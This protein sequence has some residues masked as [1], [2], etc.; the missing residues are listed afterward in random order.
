MAAVAAL[1]LSACG[2][3]TSSESS[4]D[5]TVATVQNDKPALQPIVD[6]FE[7]AHPGVKVT[8]TSADTSPYQ[9]TLQTQLVANNGPDVFYTYP[10]S[11]NPAA[12]GLLAKA[13]YLKDLSSESFVSQIPSGIQDLTKYQG[14]TYVR[15]MTVG[16]I[17]M[18]FNMDALKSAGL[19]VPDTWTGVLQLCASAKA[20]GKTAFALGGGTMS[21]VQFIDYALI[22]SLVYAKDPSFNQEMSS[23]SATFAG[24]AGWQQAMNMNVDMVKAGCF[25][26][27]P[28]G[29]QYPDAAK[30]V[31]SGQAFGIVQTQGAIAQLRVDSPSGNFELH[32]FP[33][34]DNPSDTYLASSIG[35]EY[36]INAHAKNPTLAQQFLDFLS[37]DAE[38]DA[39]ATAANSVP[40]I[41]N[42]QSAIPASIASIGEYQKENKT[43]PYPDPYWPNAQVQQAHLTGMQELLSGQGSV[44]DALK[45]M[46]SAYKG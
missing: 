36:A 15:P 25:E 11:G 23:G 19:T 1:S 30:L 33:A 16:G 17:G 5:L 28:L 29:V 21:N 44:A 32:P 34:G 4:Q 27:D 38:E 31:A 37:S 3:S 46:D 14:K 22:P 13:G 6:A 41:Q 24:S 12:E 7:K 8:L 35:A 26:K 18:V 45:G 42:A 43:F 10:G 40:A 20:Q 9:T 39:Y 2:T